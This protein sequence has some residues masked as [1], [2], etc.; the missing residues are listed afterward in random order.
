[1]TFQRTLIIILEKKKLIINILSMILQAGADVLR[2]YVGIKPHIQ[3][4]YFF[5]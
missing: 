3:L 5:F 1:M 4:P 2:G